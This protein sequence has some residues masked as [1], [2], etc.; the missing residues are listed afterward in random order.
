MT[1]STEIQRAL[2]SSFSET[3]GGT[4]ICKKVEKHFIHL[5]KKIEPSAVQNSISVLNKG[6]KEKDIH[7]TWTVLYRY[8]Y[9]LVRESIRK[10]NGGK[11]SAGSQKEMC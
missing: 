11:S 1:K 9:M 8:I 5:R 7:W 3:P 6:Q 10:Y 4:H 2:F